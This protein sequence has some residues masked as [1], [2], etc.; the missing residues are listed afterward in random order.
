MTSFSAMQLVCGKLHW[1]HNSCW[2]EP[3]PHIGS[4]DLKTEMFGVIEFPP[5]RQYMDELGVVGLCCFLYSRSDDPIP[6]S[7]EIRVMKEY[8]VKES[9]VKLMA[10]DHP[11]SAS[12]INVS[13]SGEIMLFL[14]STVVIYSPSRNLFRRASEFGYCRNIACLHIQSLVSPKVFIEDGNLS[15]RD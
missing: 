1:L 4:F 6:D 5:D 10:V 8:G 12:S 11:F 2:V 9:W 13:S 14:S 15:F 3:H 7:I